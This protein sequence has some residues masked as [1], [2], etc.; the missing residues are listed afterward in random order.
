MKTIIK[1]TTTF[2]GENF[3]R[4]DSID[5]LIEDD[6]VKRIDKQINASDADEVF[7]G[8][9]FFVTPGFINAHFHPSQQFNRALGV[10]ISHDKQM[11]LLHATDKIKKPDDKYWL[12]YLAVLE[13]LRAGT[14]CFYSVGSE[15]ETQIK[16]YNKL[17]VRAACTMIPKDIEANEKDESVRA[18]TWDTKE[19]IKTAE[20]LH[21]K[22]HSD[23]VRVHF[24]VANVRYA[25]DE[26][27]LGMQ[28]LAEK[29]DVYFHMHA[30]EANKYVESVMKR[31]GHRPV[32]HLYKTGA[33][34]HR[35]S[36][37][38]MTK[39]MPEEIKFLAEKKAHV[40]HCPRANS[41]V[42]VGVC[43]MKELIDEGV[44]VC[45]GSDAA[46]NNNSNRVLGDAHAA[47]DKLADRYEKADIIDYIT[48]F[49]MLTINGAKAMGLEKQ[50][51]TIEEG[52]KADLVLWSKNEYPF[53]PGF[54]LLADL[55]FADDGCMAH[56]V[57]INGKK[58][59]ENYKSTMM[60]EEELKQQAKKIAHRFYSLFKE[61]IF[62]NL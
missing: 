50:I 45:L 46:I 57:F 23:L 22:Y 62:K 42:A 58:V 28:K 47:H 9:D 25:S 39:L 26:L 18:K 11:D 49:K 56:T 53:I 40:V 48:L 61:R 12:S 52:K 60:N 41:Y 7:D 17:G 31:T 15:I 16:L 55:I 20:E 14:T 29:Y 5:I 8:K 19:R 30:A 35:V 37:A 33:L 34:N 6:L 51:G 32:E 38:H 54:N 4:Q 27:I 2:V 21:K 1:N 24:G 36:L 44:N 43:P 3:D 10:G 13:G 59:L